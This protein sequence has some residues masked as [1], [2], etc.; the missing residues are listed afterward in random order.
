MK[1][2]AISGERSMETGKPGDRERKMNACE[3]GGANFDLYCDLL[4]ENKMSG[5]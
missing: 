4:D 3:I 2:K 5:V 1:A